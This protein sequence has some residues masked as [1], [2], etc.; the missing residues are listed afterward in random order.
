M[1]ELFRDDSMPI[2]MGIAVY[3][4]MKWLIVP[5]QLSRRFATSHEVR[6]EREY[7]VDESGLHCRSETFRSDLSWKM[8]TLADCNEKYFFLRTGQRTFFYF[9]KD[10]VPDQADFVHLVNANVNTTK[11]WDKQYPRGNA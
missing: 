5:L 7:V 6:D 10:L 1:W 9:P 3:A 4:L 2:V 11:G 8:F